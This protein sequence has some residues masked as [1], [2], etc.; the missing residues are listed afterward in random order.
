MPRGFWVTH[1]VKALG[2]KPGDLSSISQ[3]YLV[4]GK[5]TSELLLLTVGYTFR[6]KC[7]HRHRHKIKNK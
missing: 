2:A 3:T 4:E 6:H 7:V 1:P 5:L